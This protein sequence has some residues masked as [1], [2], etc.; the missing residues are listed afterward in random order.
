MKDYGLQGSKVT[1]LPHTPGPP[2]VLKA[3]RTNW[4]DAA[5]SLALHTTTTTTTTTTGGNEQVA[6]LVSF[7]SCYAAATSEA[8]L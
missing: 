6:T 2:R 7:L 1:G 3:P 8:F 5:R 4:Y